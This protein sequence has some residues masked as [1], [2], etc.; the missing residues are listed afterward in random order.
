MQISETNPGGTPDSFLLSESTGAATAPT[1]S[2]VH[3][4]LPKI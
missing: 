3:Y 2:F 4:F 1:T